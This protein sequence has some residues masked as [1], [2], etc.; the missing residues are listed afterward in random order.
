[1]KVNLFIIQVEMFDVTL[2][3]IANDGTK[4]Y[5]LNE[6]LKLKKKYYTVFVTCLYY[7]IVND[8]PMH[9]YALVQ[10]I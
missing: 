1:M 6:A 2:Y 3:N 9:Y 7:C 10:L 8:F 5:S 4:C